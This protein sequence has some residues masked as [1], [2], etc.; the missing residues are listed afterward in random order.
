MVQIILFQALYLLL[1]RRRTRKFITISTAAA[2]IASIIPIPVTVYGSSKAALNYIIRSIHKE[3]SEEGFIVFPIL[4]GMVDTDMGPAALPL[5][6]ISKLPMTPLESAKA[7]F[8]VVDTATKDQSVKF[9]G[10]GG[11]ELPW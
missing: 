6:D 11:T 3:H 7:V 9:L 2:S 4:P 10:E 1:L 5:L 8:R